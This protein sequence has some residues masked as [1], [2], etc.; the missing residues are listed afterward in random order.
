MSDFKP[1]TQRTKSFWNRLE[2]GTNFQA[3]KNNFFPAT[4][5]LGLSL[6]YKINDKSSIGI[7]ATCKVGWGN[8]VRNIAVTRQGMGFQSYLDVEVKSSFFASG[9]FEY[10]YQP[11]TLETTGLLPGSWKPSGLFGISKI[12]SLQRKLFKKT[13]LQLLRDFLSYRQVP[14]SQPIKFRIGYNIK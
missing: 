7:G 6:G 11:L 3:E 5:D 4:T 12:V 10:N 8:N 2:Y 9:G 1:N 13:K 14:A